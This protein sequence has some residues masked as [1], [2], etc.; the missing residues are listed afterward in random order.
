MANLEPDFKD[1]LSA[2][3]DAGVEYLLIGGHALGFHGLSRTTRDIDLWVRPTVENAERVWQALEAFGAPMFM[4]DKADLTRPGMVM[5][6]GIP[7][8]RI[9]LV[10][11][12]SG[13]AFD[14]AW[15]S[16][17][18]REYDNIPVSIIGLDELIRNKRASGRDQ[19]IVDARK[20][21]RIRDRMK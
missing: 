18:Q 20:L 13:V 16:R 12:I 4:F 5:Q 19:D 1:M 7:P 6:L 21:E 2:L 11:A 14:E 9:D 17:I 8:V 3:S 10:T 15:E